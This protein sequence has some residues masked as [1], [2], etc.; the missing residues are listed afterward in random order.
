MKQHVSF[1]I[2]F[3][4][5]PHK[6]LYIVLEGINASGKNTQVSSLKKYFESQGKTV[7]TTDEP[8]HTLLVGKFVRKLITSGQQIPSSALQYLYTADRIINHQTI[9]IP[10][11]AEGK[12][13]ISS[14][15]FWSAVVYGV[16]DRGGVNYMRPDANL[17]LVSQGILSMYHNTMLPN[18]TF[19]LDIS[20]QTALNR[21]KKLRRTKDIYETREKL[22]QLLAGYRWLQ[23][24]F[25]E[26]IMSIDAEKPI[27]EVSADIL[28]KIKLK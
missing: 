17:L 1:D 2:E 8:T 4:K 3:K 6:G 24:Q 19:H 21:M 27:D 28:Q 20:V 25:N 11:L 23:K 18:Y 7:V 12:V 22:S 9:I 10:A 5:N 13:V 15:S 16:M 26:E 14:R